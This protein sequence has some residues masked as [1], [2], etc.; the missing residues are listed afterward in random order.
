MVYWYIHTKNIRRSAEFIPLVSDKESF[1]KPEGY[2][3]TSPD[4]AF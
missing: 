1:L 4:R 2:S 3:E